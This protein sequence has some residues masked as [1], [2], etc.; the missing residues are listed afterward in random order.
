MSARELQ[1]AELPV[2]LCA[3]RGGLPAEQSASAGPGASTA[4]LR[5]IIDRYYDF[6]WRTVRHFGVED[7]SAED[8]VQ[9]VLCILARRL[10]EIA[11]GAEM[12]FLFSS[13]VRVA[14]EARRATRRR[15]VTDG[16]DIDAIEVAIPSPEE[17]LDQ[18][19]ARDVLAAVI[20]GMPADL[21]AVFVLFELEELTLSQIASLVGIPVGTAAS[22]LRRARDAFHAI[23]RR[24]Q[25]KGVHAGAG[26]RP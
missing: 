15:P 4:R 12:A 16:T 13:A 10:A 7:A 5:I 9:Q 3:G 2:D 1:P 8:A 19:R 11:P 18:R 6:V 26:G 24:I 23:V 17:L 21:R 22:R 14:S 20:D 25:A